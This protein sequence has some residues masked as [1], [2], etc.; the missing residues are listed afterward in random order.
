[1]SMG[2]LTICALTSTSFQLTSLPA[3]K[4]NLNDQEEDDGDGA[5]T[6]MY[7]SPPFHEAPLSN[8]VG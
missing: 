5:L 1:M 3:E 4:V 2:G 6:S 8:Q 7:Y